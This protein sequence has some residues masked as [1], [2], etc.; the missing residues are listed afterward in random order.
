MKKRSLM[1]HT[2][3]WKHS[4]KSDY[5][6][7][8]VCSLQ[9]QLEGNILFFR[10]LGFLLSR[11]VCLPDQGYIFHVFF[12]WVTSE[13]RR[14]CDALVCVVDFLVAFKVI[15]IL[16]LVEISILMVPG[17]AENGLLSPFKGQF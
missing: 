13:Q 9:L 11:A 17:D 12:Q 16:G 3:S 2:Q 14:K 10:T 15:I 6:H 8:M 5:N 4:S 1:N 7:L